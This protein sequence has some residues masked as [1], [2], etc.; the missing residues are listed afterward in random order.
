MQ[1]GINL[2]AFALPYEEQI[3]LIKKYGFSSVFCV[4]DCKNM[5]QIATLCA[6][7]S[8][9]IESC[10]APFD[11]I[12]DIWYDT[13]D[14]ERMLH[15]LIAATDTCRDYGIPVLVVH[16]SSGE[17]PP[18]VGDLGLSRFEQL[19]AHADACGVTIAF[20]NQRMLGNLSVALET[21]PTAAFCWDCGHE[22]CFTD[23]KWDYMS[24][25]GNRLAAIHIHDNRAEHNADDHRLPFDGKI[26]FAEVAKKLAKVGYEKALMLEVFAGNSPAYTEMGA[27]A[28][29]ARAAAAAK[30]IAAAVEAARK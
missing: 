18:R 20:E 7:N 27:E 16:L 26:D 19:V 5:E 25:F 14:G 4:S 28:Y 30:K 17:Q 22:A 10:H 24:L 9:T 13:D 12:N 23:G 11:H 29:Y 2:D 6:Q 3:A 1:I 15:E 8:L 21:F